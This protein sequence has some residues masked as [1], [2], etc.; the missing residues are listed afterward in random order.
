[1]GMTAG[2]QIAILQDR[3][4]Q[5]VTIFQTEVCIKYDM[6]QNLWIYWPGVA[7]AKFGNWPVK[8]GPNFGGAQ[9]GSAHLRRGGL[10]GKDRHCFR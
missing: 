7:E 10:H 4:H 2:A 8:M 6:D 1:M 9:L 3:Y 5:C